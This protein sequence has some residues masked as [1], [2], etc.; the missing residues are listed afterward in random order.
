MGEGKFDLGIYVSLELVKLKK[1]EREREGSGFS[2][3]ALHTQHVAR[4]GN[5]S[6]AG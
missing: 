2:S 3:S 4:N 1:K 6:G 5:F